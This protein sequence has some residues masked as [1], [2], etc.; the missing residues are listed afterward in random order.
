[1]KTLRGITSVLITLLSLL[2]AAQTHA[3]HLMGSDLTWTCIGNDS[4]L[5]QLTIYRDCNGVN[6][7]SASIPFKCVSTGLTITTITIPRPVPTDITPVSVLGSNCSNSSSE[8]QTRCDNPSSTYPYGIEQYVYQKI[9]VLS[10]AGSC[11]KVN[12]SWESCCRNLPITTGMAGDWFSVDATLDR[13][14]S[15]CDNSPSF[16]NP[17]ISIICLGQDFVFNHGVVDIDVSS[18]GGLIDSLSYEWTYPKGQNGAD[19]SYSGQYDYNKPIYFWGFPNKNLPYPRGFHL[20][21]HTG[22]IM[23]R[24]MKIEQTV[25]AVKISEYRNGVKIGEVRRDLQIIVISC[26]NNNAPILSGPFYKEICA[27]N[28]VTFTINT[29]DYDPLDTLLISW[30][31]GIPGGTWTDNNCIVKHPTGTMTWTPGE[32]YAS[33]IPYVFTV[34]V[35][36]DGVPVKGRATR[37]YQV[38]VKPLP[39]ALITVTDSGCGDYHLIAQ[40]ILGSNHEYQ[41]VGNFNPGFVNTGP[42]MHYRFK[43]PGEYPYSLIVKA[44][45]CER[46]YF[47]TIIVDTFL[48]VELED[49]ELCKGDMVNL[50]ANYLNNAGKTEILWS[51]STSDTLQNLSFTSTTDTFVAVM[52]SDS[53]QCIARDTAFVNVHEKPLVNLNENTYICKNGYEILQPILT[54]DESKLKE[55]QWFSLPDYAL[56]S[57]DT[58]LAVSELG[59][60][61]CKVEDSM[62]C[63]AMD[64]TIV[65]LNPEVKALAEG[66]KICSGETIVIKADSS[67]SKTTNVLYEWYQGATIIGIGQELQVSPLETTAYCLK[68]SEI[69]NGIECFDSLEIRVIVNPLPE[70]ILSPIDERCISGSNSTLLQLDNYVQVSPTYSTINWNSSSS[71]LVNSNNFSPVLAGVGDHTVFLEVSNPVT[72]CTFKGEL[73]IKIHPLPDVSAGKDVEL[74]S[75]DP[76]YALIGIPQNASSNWYS[77]VPNAIEKNSNVYYFNPEVLAI[78]NEN[79]YALI[80]SFTD[81][82]GCSNTD[83]VEMTVFK[84]PEPI[85]G[86]YTDMCIDGNKISLIG[87]PIGGLWTGKG[88]MNNEFVPI[89]AGI[90]EH[91]LNYEVHNGIC[92]AQDQTTIVVNPLPKLTANTH[93]SKRIFCTNAD[94]VELFGTP[95]GGSWSGE[96]VVGNYFDPS[97]CDKTKTEFELVYIYEDGNGCVNHK[98]L[99]LNTKPAPEILI[100]LQQ[101]VLCFPEIFSTTATYKN[102]DGIEWYKNNDLASG[103][104]VG[105]INQPTISYQADEGDRFRQYFFLFAKSI[106]TDNICHPDFDSIKV[107]VNDIPVPEFETDV[108]EGCKPLEVNFFDKSSIDYGEINYWRWTTGDGSI[109]DLQNPS[110]L[111]EEAG[112]YTISLKTMSKFGCEST[113]VKNHFITVHDVP[114][115]GFIPEQDLIKLS[116]PKVV[117]QNTSTHVTPL[118]SYNWNFGDHL[119]SQGGYSKEKNPV[120]TYSDTGKYKVVLFAENEFGCS[121]FFERIIEVLP[122]A[123]VFIPSA[124]S[125]NQIGPDDNNVF[126]VFAESITDFNLKVYSSWGELLY[127]AN[128]YETHAWP[129]TYYQSNK[130]VPQ[131]VYVYILQVKDEVGQ[132][133]KYTGTVTLLK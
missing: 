1:M 113:L 83:T 130:T 92:S 116:L 20:N 47:D 133:Y 45:G 86:S 46:V 100:D 57:K 101:N 11:C 120:Y 97:I 79:G 118:T 69:L 126:K 41:W 31:G 8:I 14:I 4:F 42:Y 7:G 65:F 61:L 91:I 110:Y 18:G 87:S 28:T 121:D 72:Q 10:G 60:Y 39:K 48:R 19:L 21:P 102:A 43:K 67:G 9:V 105:T 93:N 70:V 124:F 104:F 76:K 107:M 34:T 123:I 127:E 12:M 33:P 50:T 40:A 66:G 25:M 13:C 108:V 95:S 94:L 89:I 32:E 117:F 35:V 99:I 84:T 16:T 109:L 82:N 30:N 55:M 77:S 106:Q 38:L 119:S 103:A 96:G 37:A 115:A 6:V 23:F 17:P 88:V 44:N 15:P 73:K 2:F 122:D 132:E 80:Y 129:G 63:I 75:T 131:D 26:P 71:G 59:K 90:G 114:K 62:G 111:F 98:S 58:M 5:I 85:A 125:P 54:F 64:S 51:T 27:T 49:I 68:V 74:C 81:F 22:D 53:N 56:L 78:G 3:T 29:Y 128:D 36:D 24:P 112:S 52:I